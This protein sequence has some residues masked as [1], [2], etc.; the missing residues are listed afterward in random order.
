MTLWDEVVRQSPEWSD[1]LRGFLGRAEGWS[2]HDLL[3]VLTESVNRYYREREFAESDVAHLRTR[4]SV[5]GRYDR[6]LKRQRDV[7]DD[8]CDANR[9]WGGHDPYDPYDRSRGPSSSK[10]MYRR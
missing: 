8:G 10:A 5:M 7:G 1:T 2:V 3:V 4:L 9:A 6:G